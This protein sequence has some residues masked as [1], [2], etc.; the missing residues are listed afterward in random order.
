MLNSKGT[1]H[2]AFIAHKGLRTISTYIYHTS[3]LERV[4]YFRGFATKYEDDISV[5]VLA[6]EVELTQWPHIKPACLPGA[7]GE[8]DQY[9]GSQAVVSGW[10]LTDFYNGS[11]PKHLREGVNIKQH[12]C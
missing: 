7:D 8:E 3:I 2:L 9:A 12:C 5:L 11:Y 6:E 10:G 1:C 4:F